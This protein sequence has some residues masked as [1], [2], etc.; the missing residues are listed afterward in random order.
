M[1]PY[2][3]EAIPV[4]ISD[5][6]RLVSIGSTLDCMCYVVC[7]L[8]VW[9]IAS[10]FRKVIFSLWSNFGEDS[11]LALPARANCGWK[12]KPKPSKSTSSSSESLWDQNSSIISLYF[13]LLISSLFISVGLTWVLGEMGDREWNPPD[14]PGKLVSFFQLFF[15]LVSVS[16]WAFI[17]LSQNLLKL[18][19]CLKFWLIFFA[20]DFSFSL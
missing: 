12:S 9:F 6:V 19:C 1:S 13:S 14:P 11:S 20:C 17:A 8:Q 18:S 4:C 10:W 2:L 16:L 5:A 15:R 7:L 3:S